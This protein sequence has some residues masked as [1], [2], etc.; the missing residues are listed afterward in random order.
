MMVLLVGLLNRLDGILKRVTRIVPHILDDI[1]KDDLQVA[2]RVE[3]SGQARPMCRLDD[4]LVPRKHIPPHLGRRQERLGFEPPIIGLD[5]G[6]D[7]GRANTKFVIP[8]QA[9][10]DLLKDSLK[11]IPILLTESTSGRE[12][13]SCKS[14]DE[15]RLFWTIDSPLFKSAEA[16]I[17][18]T[19]GNASIRAVVGALG[20][21]VQV[22]RE[23]LLSESTGVSNISSLAFSGREIARIVLR[24]KERRLDLAWYK[25]SAPPRWLA[26]PTEWSRL[27]YELAREFSG[28]R[29]YDLRSANIQVL[30]EG[31]EIMGLGNEA[32][33]RHGQG[34]LLVGDYPA[35]CYVRSML[36]AE[37]N[38]GGFDDRRPPVIGILA[39]F[40][41]LL[42]AQVSSEKLDQFVK[43]L[44]PLLLSQVSGRTEMEES[45]EPALRSQELMTAIL[46]SEWSL[47]DPSAWER[48]DF[49]D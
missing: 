18:E 7:R 44:V 31:V 13:I 21:D 15:D 42:F 23:R 45:W 27:C 40:H 39:L 46:K 35:T 28:V 2:A 6:S 16:L 24:P 48:H 8:Y 32:A 12:A 38:K 37:L 43:R 29:L 49:Y 30:L 41:V 9:R 3:D 47:F 4:A 26:L 33:I 1:F 22:P 36:E 17:R 11:E 5:A 25:K 10:A 34:T 20:A 19:P 14:L